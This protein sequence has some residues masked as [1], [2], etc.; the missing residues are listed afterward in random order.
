VSLPLASGKLPASEVSASCRNLRHAIQRWQLH[1]SWE[2][3]DAINLNNEID[4][5]PPE[6]E[7][8]KERPRLELINFV[9]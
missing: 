4:S 9:S 3:W 6:E 5:L 2:R 1:K 8:P 7:K